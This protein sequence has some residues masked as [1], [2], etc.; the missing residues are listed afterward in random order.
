M[1]SNRTLVHHSHGP[2]CLAKY[3]KILKNTEKYWMFYNYTLVHHSPLPWKYWKL[4]KNAE[5]YWKILRKNTQ[6]N[7]MFSNL[8]LVHHSHGPHLPCY[9]LRHQHPRHL[10]QNHVGE[11]V[12]PFTLSWIYRKSSDEEIKFHHW[13]W[14]LSKS[15][16][17]VSRLEL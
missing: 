12:H 7:R 9:Q 15:V 3:W 4:F 1:F 17:F 6:K 2:L 14:A 8:T 13:N 5:K 16:I 11:K 10:E